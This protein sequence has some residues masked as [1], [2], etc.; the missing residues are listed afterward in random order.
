MNTPVVDGQTLRRP[1]SFLVQILAKDIGVE[2]E[3]ST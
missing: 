1:F 2:G 3:P